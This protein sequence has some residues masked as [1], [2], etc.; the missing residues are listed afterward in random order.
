M[1]TWLCP[2][3]LPALH[4]PPL[5]SPPPRGCRSTWCFLLLFLQQ[6]CMP[7]Y[8]WRGGGLGGRGG[9]ASA[10]RGPKQ[11]RIA[12]NLRRAGGPGSRLV[13]RGWGWQGRGEAVELPPERC[14]LGSRGACVGAGLSA[15]PCVAR[16]GAGGLVGEGM[17]RAGRWG[18]VSALLTVARLQAGPPASPVPGSR[19]RLGRVQGVGGLAPS[20]KASSLHR[21]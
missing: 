1:S 2:P 14:A 16:V 15:F 3:S 6:M 11:L 12:E 21:S 10:L 17:V 8:V 5:T 9:P 19:V 4:P 18:T 7:C 13:A 20:W